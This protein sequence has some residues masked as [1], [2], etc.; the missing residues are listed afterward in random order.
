MEING[1]TVSPQAEYRQLG[2]SDELLRAID[3]YQHR[4]R[5]FGGVK[6]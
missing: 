5:R 4:D 6:K 2:L 3:A 1:Q